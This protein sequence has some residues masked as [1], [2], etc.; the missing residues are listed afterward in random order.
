M[1]GARGVVDRAAEVESLAGRGRPLAY[2]VAFAGRG[3]K[4][5][6]RRYVARWSTVEKVRLE[7]GGW[8]HQTMSP[9]RQRE[10]EATEGRAQ[11]AAEGSVA[12]VRDRSSLEDVELK[13]KELTEALPT[14]QQDAARCA[15]FVPYREQLHWIDKRAYKTHPL[16]ALERWITKYQVLHPKG[17][18]VGFCAGQ[19]VYPRS[20]VQTLHTK[21]RWLREMRRVRDKET[22]CKVVKMSGLSA[23][24]A[25]ARASSQGGGGGGGGGGEEAMQ[26][27]FDE[28]VASVS[29][30]TAGKNASAPPLE[31]ELFGIWQTDSWRPPPA[32]D[33]IVP[34]N[35]RGHV[36]VWNENCLP[37]GTV[38]LR[39]PYIGQLSTKLGIDYAMAMVGFE[40]RDRRSAPKF[41]G[42]VICKASREFQEALLAAHAEDEAART[43]KQRWKRELEAAA[44]WRHL[45]KSIEVR[46]RLK[47]EYEARAVAA[48]EEAVNLNSEA[49]A[50][51]EHLI[52]NQAS[53]AQ[54]RGQKL[55]AAEAKRE[56]EELVRPADLDYEVI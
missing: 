46:Q 29:Y 50:V 17:P 53:A 7:E 24:A 19:P 28:L 27:E 40:I 31:T 38:H 44:R 12:G 37:E 55:R 3:A 41:D 6:T 34:K 51:K 39:L 22:P 10:A 45:L 16:Y 52:N 30:D 23:A 2:V 21:D 18:V 33:G 42:I 15:L 48:K 43:E 49:V 13:T 4:D 54:R 35:E 8:W 9:L 47:R 14:N 5:V 32:R 1:D 25:N 36:D 20:C 11:E 56:E 26:E